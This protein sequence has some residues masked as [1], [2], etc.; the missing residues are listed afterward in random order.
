MKRTLSV[1]LVLMMLVALAFPAF[2]EEDPETTPP[3][4]DKEPE[5]SSRVI[6]LN[7]NKGTVSPTSVTLEDGNVL[8]AL[9]MPTR[10][11]WDFVGWYTAEITENFYGDD[12]GETITAW[13]GMGNS[14][15]TYWSWDI[16]TSGTLVTAG[17]TLEESVTTLYAM[18]KPQTFTVR[19]HLNGWH[20]ET[21]LAMTNYN[22]QYDS[23][24]TPVV[25]TTGR[26]AW[27]GRTFEGWYTEPQGGS[28]WDSFTTDSGAGNRSAARVT[29]DLDLY[30]HWSGGPEA[31]TIKIGNGVSYSLE[32]GESVNVPVSYSPSDAN[33]PALTWTSSDVSALTVTASGLTATLTAVKNTNSTDNRYVT[34]TA[35]TQDGVSASV[36]VTIRHN[37]DSGKYVKEPSCTE[38]GTVRYTCKTCGATTDREL[39]ANGHRYVY[40]DI[41]AT[42]EEQG[43]THRVCNVCGYYE[44]SD[45]T[46][47]LGH[48]WK[49]TVLSS[50]TGTV[51]VKE[52]TVCLMTETHSDENAETHDWQSD[53]TVDKA[54]TCSEAGSQSIHC[55]NC[56]MTKDSA[57]IP[58][59]PALHAFSDWTQTKAATT[60]EGGEE[61]RTCSACGTTETRE[62]DPLPAETPTDPGEP[63]K[64]A[65]PEGP[66]E[67]DKPTVPDE[68]TEPETPAGK[69]E[70]V[71]EKDGKTYCYDENGDKLTGLQTVEGKTY[72]FSIADGHMMRGGV[73]NAGDGRYYYLSAQDGHVLKGGWINGGSGKRYYAASDGHLMAGGRFTDPDSGRIYYLAKNGQMLTGFHTSGKLSFYYSP[74]DGHMMKGG[75]VRVDGKLYYLS[76][77]DGHVMKNGWVNAGGG[78]YYRLDKDGVVVETK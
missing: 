28:L 26:Y 52:C 1:L 6:A 5:V 33:I 18:Y 75:L 69:K 57:T 76:A 70:L 30:A 11:G 56:D 61:S 66:T 13:T 64:P 21:G 51:T 46:A 63:D 22:Q 36:E 35:T 8:P 31:T 3:A 44:D 12:P 62:T 24:L 23:P 78:K 7:A 20:K 32:P 10:T 49:T 14:K 55:K 37:W 74:A 50:C 39:P 34:V 2:A 45:F 29:G 73:V 72:Y 43:H 71:V 47:A 27:E 38:G 58:T 42:C 65:E 59:D 40:S 54:P 17:G 60:T 19:W 48:T 77:R 16:K 67:P 9:P 4:E 15:E 53:Y 25:L 68:P 41:P